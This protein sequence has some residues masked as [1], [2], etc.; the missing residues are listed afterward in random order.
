MNEKLERFSFLTAS[1]KFEGLDDEDSQELKS[2]TSVIEKEMDNSK[3]LDEIKK[4]FD[5]YHISGYFSVYKLA[6][7]MEIEHE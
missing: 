6:K 2:L 7:I 1:Y 3:K 4:L 5:D